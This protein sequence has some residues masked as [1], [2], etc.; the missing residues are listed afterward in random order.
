MLLTSLGAY[1]INY[2]SFTFSGCADTYL[3]NKHLR[4]RQSETRKKGW[5]WYISEIGQE[6]QVLNRGTSFCVLS[7]PLGSFDYFIFVPD[8]IRSFFSPSMYVL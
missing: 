4:P 6:V 8:G 3:M 2:F 7:N 5:L 1:L